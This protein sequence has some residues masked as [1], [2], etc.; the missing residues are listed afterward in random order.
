MTAQLLPSVIT[1]PFNRHFDT[2]ANIYCGSWSAYPSCPTISSSSLKPFCVYQDPQ[3]SS[4]SIP[5]VSSAPAQ[6][7]KPDRD[8]P[9]SENIL[10]GLSRQTPGPSS[11]NGVKIHSNHYESLPIPED[12]RLRLFQPTRSDVHGGTEHTQRYLASPTQAAHKLAEPHNGEKRTQGVHHDIASSTREQHRLRTSL[13]TEAFFIEEEEYQDLSTY[14]REY[15]RDWFS[16]VDEPESLLERSFLADTSEDTSDTGPP[17]GLH[18][19]RCSTAS[20]GFVHTM[21][22]ASLS[23]ASFS[24]V[25]RSLRVG[26]SRDDSYIFS[27]SARHSVESDRPTTSASVDEAA[28]RRAIKRR[29]ILVELVTSEESYIADLKALI[30]LYSTLLATTMT[31]PGRVRSSLLRNVHDLLS[32]HEKLLERLH[33]AAYEAAAR[34][35]ADTTSPRHLGSPPYHKRWKSLESSVAAKLGRSNRRARSSIESTEVPRGRTYLG[36]AEPRDVADVAGIFRHFLSDFLVYEEYCANHS[37]ISRELQRHSPALWSTYESGIESLAR[38]LAALDRK[39]QSE[40][41]G[42]TVGDLLIKPIQRMTKYPLLFDDLLRQTP[43]ADCPTAHSDLEAIMTCLREVVQTVNKATDNHETRAQIQRR[44]SLQTRLICDKVSLR[45]E[46]FR[47]LGNIQLSGVLHV[48][49]QT[50]T[51]KVD[52]RY[53]LCMLFD[54]SL[55]IALPAGATAKF[56]A[57]AFLH[58]RDTRVESASDGRGL[59]CHSTLYTWKICFEISGHLHEFIL[60]ACSAIEESAWRGGLQ[61]KDAP[62]RRMAELLNQIPSSISLNLRSIGQVYSQQSSTLSRNPSVQRAATVGN[63]ATVCQVIIR[64]TSN[65]QDLHEFRQPSS[66][67]IN[68][69]QSHMTSNR[70]VVLAPKRSQRSR[71]E[72]TLGDVWTKEKLPYPGM[73][74]SRSGQI[75]RASAGSLARKLSLSSIHTPFSRRSGSLSLSSRKSFDLSNESRHS[76]TK[77]S[78]PIFEIRKES[79]DELPPARTKSREIPEVDTMDNVVSRMIGSSLSRNVSI[80]QGHHALARRGTKSLKI[81]QDAGGPEVGPEDPAEIYYAESKEMPEQPE[82]VEEGLAGRKKRWSNPLGIL[83]VL[84]ADGLR[85]MLYS[86]K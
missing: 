34:K 14:P 10:P 84:S 4:A 22:T 47:M 50:R 52:G 30:Y 41:K 72:S 86:S 70:V 28:F 61:N 3:S 42:L 20:S 67:L 27:S 8:L 45:V 49:W 79:L 13:S 33:Q 65:P 81:D 23:N 2:S 71:L 19:K 75:I 12:P 58:L 24:L 39:R 68:R 9:S 73:I 38:S 7:H 37:L 35:W 74:T 17:L 55:I 66:S 46:Q 64:N 82:I 63:R 78:T 1:S 85:H 83:K 76:K 57:V 77:P 6:V 40:R 18:R 11:T 69:S 60:S 25:P 54:T 51:N 5:S 32:L 59:Q 62:G 80:S 29:Q 21:K 15:T 53:A 26:R 56:E 36:G 43:V 16:A 44:W 48:T 31:V